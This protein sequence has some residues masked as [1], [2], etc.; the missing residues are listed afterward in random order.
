[1]SSQEKQRRAARER[2]RI[3]RLDPTFREKMRIYQQERRQQGENRELARAYQENRRRAIGILSRN[4]QKIRKMQY[5][6]ETSNQLH[7]NKYD[8]TNVIYTS[9]KSKVEIVCRLHGVFLQTPERHLQGQGCPKCAHVRRVESRKRH[10]PKELIQK[11]NE[12]HD[13][14]YDYSDVKYKNLITKIE[15][16]CVKHGT[17]TQTPKA[18]LRGQGCPTCANDKRA[19]FYES[20]GEKKIHEWLTNRNHK[21]IRQKTFNDLKYK[22]L[23]RYD[24]FLPEKNIIIEFDGQQH[25]QFVA[26][27]HGSIEN[28]ESM[29]RRDE[30]KNQYAKEN[31]YKLVRIKWL[32]EQNIETILNKHIL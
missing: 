25:Y 13:S 7:N 30:I 28:F 3:K 24:F 16:K 9:Q 11:F 23:L 2:M 5:F 18:H 21:V 8:Y 6:V 32:E 29:K 1:M 27:F 22:M 10:D 15:I 12:I 31:N 26:K 17:F 4:D 19:S 14:K 20:R